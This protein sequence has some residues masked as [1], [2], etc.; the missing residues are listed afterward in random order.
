MQRILE[1]PHPQGNGV[2]SHIHTFPVSGSA[3]CRAAFRS[4]AI[5]IRM[6]EFNEILVGWLTMRIDLGSIKMGS[7][8]E[9]AMV[10]VD[11]RGRLLGCAV[12]LGRRWAVTRW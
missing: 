10:R 2:R 3:G 7:S 11:T 9:D 5:G 1:S 6:L 12:S 8:G 4:L